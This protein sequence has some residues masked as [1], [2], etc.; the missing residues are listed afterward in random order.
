MVFPLVLMTN[1]MNIETIWY[2]YIFSYFYHYQYI[3]QTDLK[4]NH[5]LQFSTNNMFACIRCIFILINNIKNIF[6]VTKMN[7]II[8]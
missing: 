6:D 3:T 8:T 4:R 1:K 2:N 5:I 7:Y